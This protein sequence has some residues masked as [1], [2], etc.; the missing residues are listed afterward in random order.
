MA[1]ARLLERDEALAV[2]GRA[3]DDA[4]A[5]SGG[6]VL[7]AGEAGVG[8][9]AL[10][11]QFAEL[12]PETHVAWGRCD[13]LATPRPLGPLADISAAIG[14]TVAHLLDEDAPRGE[15]FQATLDALCS[16]ARPMIVVL[17]DVHG[18]DEATLDLVRFLARRIG[19]HPIVIVLT[20]RDDEIGPTHPLWTVLGDLAS[21][22]TAGRVV[23]HP[24]SIDAVAELSRGRHVDAA[25]VHRVTAGNPFFVTEVLATSS[26]AVPATVRDA[27]LGRAA[28]LA[29]AAR[30]T[31]DAASVIPSR[32]EASLLRVLAG[33][34]TRAVDDC[35]AHGLLVAGPDWFGFRH[36]LA[37]LVVEAALGPA[38]RAELHRRALAFLQARGTTPADLARLVHH[39]VAAGDTAVVADLAP[40][41]GE[42]AA[43]V[44]AHREAAAHL[45]TALA[46]AGG[47]SQGD[48]DAD[49]ER[50]R[51]LERLAYERYLTDQI[52]GA[53]EARRQALGCWHA[54]GDRLREGDTLRWLSRL[55]WF[56]AR[57]ADA[58]RYAEEA[59]RL[60]ADQPPGVELARAYSNRAQ[61][62]MLSHER[63]GALRWGTEAIALSEQLGDV[64]TLA[65]ALNNLG[66]ARLIDGDETGQADLERSLEIA[67]RHGMEEHVARAYTNLASIAV[68]QR[69]YEPADGWL[70]DGIAYATDHD[71]DSW[72]L[73]M[74]GWRARSALE[75]GRWSDATRDAE[76]VLH[77]PRTAPVSRIGALVVLGTVRARRG[78][79]DIWGPLDEAL[80][81]AR[82]SDEVQ[83]LAPVA[84]ARIE[85]AWLAGTVEKDVGLAADVLDRARRLGTERWY[86]GELAV[87]VRRAGASPGAVADGRVER[88]FALEL[89]GD[90]GA[91]AVLWDEIGCPYEAALA[92][93]FT[94]DEHDLRTAHDR[95][96]AL[97]A[98]P[99]A[100]MVARRMRQLG[101]RR[102]PRGPRPRTR[103][104][105]GRLTARELEVLG[106]V[107]DGL[108][109]AAIAEQMSVSVKTVDH[110][111]SS[112]LAKLGVRSRREVAQAARRLGWEETQT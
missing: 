22:G 43:S 10:L 60:L 90:G 19:D 92:L 85:A 70:S 88:P 82:S 42:Y 78:D 95:F 74:Q 87:W 94:A 69:R 41:A 96:V 3:L 79:P 48:G 75:R 53:I 112:I 1:A 39:A 73:Y 66:T 27:V 84:A 57:R 17:E 4:A 99:A 14:G 64:E 101:V 62:A 21:Q 24:L 31:L 49:P 106:L 37:R 16:S 23:L 18:A 65:H 72:R 38:T 26:P 58:L 102:V 52:E 8:K 2:L 104:N 36:E 110:H 35:V 86:T 93:A 9:T 34:D 32:V 91:A 11:T 80:D 7:V 44:G 33:A 71:L 76:T 103:T 6:V 46:A 47:T 51:L 68:S 5:G 61:L 97:D 89:D 50:A 81:L 109:N 55:S 13:A 59:V 77:H 105:P 56:L 107:V 67:S 29:P 83:R 12:H 98:R 15:L 111:V 25:A 54:G 100:A 40:R 28:R 20:Y 108:T 63:D 30:A 45:E